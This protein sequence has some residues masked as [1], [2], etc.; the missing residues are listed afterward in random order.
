MQVWN[1]QSI[2][3]VR[4]FLE[5]TTGQVTVAVSALL[6]AFASCRLF[7]KAGFHGA[8]GLLMLVPGLNLLVYLVLALA[9][10]PMRREVRQLR[11][12]QKAVHRADSRQQKKA[13]AA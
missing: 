1:D 5:G 9:P 2:E 10:W 13:K 12:M 8:L 11:Q 4:A 6:F 3:S 7:S